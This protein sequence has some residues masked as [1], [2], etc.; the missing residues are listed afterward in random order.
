MT[1]RKRAIDEHYIRKASDETVNN[2]ATVQSDDVLL[3]PVGVSETWVFTI[4]LLYSSSGSA[5]FKH[6]FSVPSGT[7]G[8]HQRIG[9]TTGGLTSNAPYAIASAIS[10][11]AGGGDFMMT[12]TG[13]VRSST[14]AGNVT[15]QWAQAGAESSDTKVLANSVL[16]ALRVD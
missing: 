7:T 10:S 13:V 5:D 4:Y 6:Q 1:R 8:F 3:F 12:I 2:S 16:I 11:S 9:L 14:T 15:F